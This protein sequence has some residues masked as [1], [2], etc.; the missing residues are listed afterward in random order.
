MIDG[1]AR[2]RIAEYLADLHGDYGFEDCEKVE[3]DTQGS[4]GDTPLIIAA[5]RFDVQIVSDLLAAGAD[6]NLIGEDDCTALHHAAFRGNCEIIGLLLAHGA[7]A[8]LESMLGTPAEL[9][10]RHTEAYD[11]LTRKQD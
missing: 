5:I 11:L 7:R 2:C 8:D 4:F 6:P 3:I 9:A 1:H 10:E